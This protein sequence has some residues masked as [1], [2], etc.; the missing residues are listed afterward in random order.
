MQLRLAKGVA[1]RFLR[2]QLFLEIEAGAR[3]ADVTDVG[4]RRAAELLQEA[5]AVFAGPGGVCANV[6]VVDLGD[7]LTALVRLPLATSTDSDDSEAQPLVVP[8]ERLE[9]LEEALEVLAPLTHPDA[10]PAVVVQHDVELLRHIQMEYNRSREAR[11]QH[12]IA[13]LLAR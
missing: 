5:A 9:R 3:L 6:S 2:D 12:R 4:R 7:V 11:R 10:A 8:A 1:A 13:K